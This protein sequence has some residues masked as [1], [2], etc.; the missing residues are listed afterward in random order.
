VLPRLLVAERF[1][2]LEGLIDRHGGD[3][4]C[5]DVAALATPAIAAKH[6]DSNIDSLCFTR[7]EPTHTGGRN[8]VW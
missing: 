8:D 3:F 7:A 2:L 5:F 4:I 6:L 1:E